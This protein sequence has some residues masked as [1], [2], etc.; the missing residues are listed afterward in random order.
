M[1]L[2]CFQ[3]N[4]ATS[5][6]QLSKSNSMLF[7]VVGVPWGPRRVNYLQENLGSSEGGSGGEFSCFFEEIRLNFHVFLEL[8]FL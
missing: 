6:K 7:D 8:G 1:L 5:L 2:N 4:L 3:C